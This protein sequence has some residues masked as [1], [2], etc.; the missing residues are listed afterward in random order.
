MDKPPV[1]T[2]WRHKRRQSAYRIA[3]YYYGSLEE[4]GHK[5]GEKTFYWRWT[6]NGQSY[7]DISPF[8][9]YPDYPSSDF[10][11][12]LQ[13]EVTVQTSDPGRVG[14]LVI[15]QSCDDGKMWIRPIEEFMDGRFEQ[16]HP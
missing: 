11:I 1:G 5:D 10:W 12:D 15:Y 9:P 13:I 16:V 3:G 2:I 8:P 7:V 14:V 6:D 4:N